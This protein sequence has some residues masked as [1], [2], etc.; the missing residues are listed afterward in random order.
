VTICSTIILI[1]TYSYLLNIEK[2]AFIG[3]W[4]VAWTINLIAQ[5]ITLITII[6]G[7]NN[8]LVLISHIIFIISAMVLLLGTYSFLNKPVPVWSTIVIVISIIWLIHSIILKKS[9]LLTSV[10]T[11]LVLGISTIW[12]GIIFLYHEEGPKYLYRILGS[13]FILWGIHKMDYMF[14]RNIPNFAIWGYAISAVFSITIT[15]VFIFIHFEKI[16]SELIGVQEVLSASEKRMVA[17][18]ENQ[19]EIIF[20]LDRLGYLTFVS[21]ACFDMT[22]YSHDYM[23][24]KSFID[25]ISQD[26]WEEVKNSKPEGIFIEKTWEKK[27]KSTLYVK[28]Y[29]KP[30]F[31]ANHELEGVFGSIHNITESKLLNEAMEYYKLKTEFFANISHELKTPLNV[32]LG[33]TQLIELYSK[34]HSETENVKKVRRNLAT[35]KQNVFRLSRLINNL[36]DITIV[37]AGFFELQIHNYNIVN[38]IENVTM[39]VVDYIENKGI[40]IEFDTEIEEKIIA[41]DADKIERVM[42]NLLSNS[43]KFTSAG[44]SIMVKII[45]GKEF[46]TISVKDTGIGIA[47]DKQEMIFERFRQVDKSLSRNNEGSGI[48]LSLVKSLVELHKGTVTVESE[49]GF[50]S[51]FIIQLPITK[52]D[53]GLSCSMTENFSIGKTDIEFSDIY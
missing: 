39:S 26:T 27:D 48:G 36:I 38:V 49:Y 2:K 33:S 29:C 9:F 22:G 42:L 35:I 28:I 31:N 18:I 11:S 30:S 53:E 50:G 34:E 37:D 24:G 7:E 21:P 20:E 4:A 46:I 12:V 8:T 25:F 52:V 16:R 45:D 19:R 3:I 5:I 41:F 1:I 15:V 17:I 14:F 40:S 10:P 43:S 6:Q 32:I 13:C 44:G 51:E 23:K 47:K